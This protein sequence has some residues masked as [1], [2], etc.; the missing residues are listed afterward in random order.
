[1][2]EGVLALLGEYGNILPRYTGPR[3]L[4]ERQ[5]VGGCDLCAVS[6][7]HEAVEIMGGVSIDPERCTGCGLCVQSCPT[8]ALEYDLLPVLNMVRQQ[9]EQSLPVACAQSG[10][11]GEV[12]PCLGR[13]TVSAVVAAGGWDMPLTLLHGECH[14]CAVG[15]PDVP[16][17]LQS[18]VDSAQALRKVTGR[19]TRVNIR[20]AEAGETQAHHR[21][22]RRGLFGALAR[23]AREVVAH[24]IPESPLPFVDWSIPEERRPAEWLWRKKALRPAPAPT[25]PLPWPAPRIAPGCIDCPVCANVCPTSAI[26]RELDVS[27]TLTL[28]L[29]LQACTSC[30]ACARSCPPQVISLESD[31]TEQDFGA[32][33]LLYTKKVQE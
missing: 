12:L 28:H 1:M 25:Q 7:P 9:G 21:V 26:I 4:V 24:T 23:Q 8:G 3:C 2:L 5:V 6:C 13:V 27:G 11:G 10:V 22:S 31:F 17:R 19:P 30:G 20:G 16:E 15:G 32:P 18:V 33:V 14:T 29:D